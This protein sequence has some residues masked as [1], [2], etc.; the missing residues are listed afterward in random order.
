VNVEIFDEG[1]D[2]AD[3]LGVPAADGLL[4]KGPEP[5]VDG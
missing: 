4:E 5:V 3:Q 2:R 1:A